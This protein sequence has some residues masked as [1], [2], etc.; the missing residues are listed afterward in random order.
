MPP[1]FQFRG[2]DRRSQNHH[3]KPEFTFRYSRPPTSERPLL[4]SRRETTPDLLVAPEN[5]DDKPALKF[6]PIESLSDSEEADMDVSSDENDDDESRPRKKRALESNKC[7]TPASAPT[8][9]PA[10]KW[11]NPDP[12]T[13]LPPP[14][15]TQS[16]RVDVVKL[17]RKA[18][19][20]ASAQPAKTDAVADNEDFISLGGLVDEEESKYQPPQ[21]APMGPRSQMQGRDSAV[22]SRKRTHDDELK[23]VSKKTG[24]PLNKYYSD[25]SIIDEWRVRP[26]ETGA[27]W[28]NHMTP[29]LHL[30]DLIERLQTAFQSRYYG[31]QLR[32]FGSFASGL[33]LPTADIDLVLLSS[34]FMRHGIK[35]FGERKGQI[36]AFSAFLRNLDIAVPGSIETIAHARVPILKFVDKMTGLRVDLSFDNDSGL[37]ANNTFQQ[38]KSEYPAMPVIVSVIKQFLLLR[39][40]NEVPCGGLGG[41]SITCLVTSLLQHL[42]HGS[43]SQNLGSIL[44]D[45]FEFYGHEFDYETVGIRMEPP[46]YFNKD[47]RLS[48]ED[49]NNA[50]NDVSGGTREIALIFKSFRDA[51]RLLKERMVYTAMAGDQNNSI[52]ESIIAANYDEYTEQRWQLRQ[53][54]QT[55]PRFARYQAPPSPPPPPQSPPPADSAPPPL[56]PNSPPPSQEPKEKMT[57]LQRKQQASRERAARLKRLRPDLPSVPDSITNEQALIIGGYKSQSDMDK[58]LANREKELK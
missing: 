17:I 51:Y 6:A 10:P 11:S 21:D 53:I 22:G 26:S 16:K 57:K 5:G 29:T 24:K 47:A 54:F 7:N 35:T 27:P 36:Y 44:M 41:F 9:P 12:Y 18:R 34:N 40:L 15:E 50:D 4:R 2:N 28:F 31:V 3:P 48:I 46:G 56:P 20:A 55:H 42:P 33:Y 38:W 14:D 52:L 13:V 58:D 30:A 23:G 25:G 8:P 43:M 39:G 45:F 1:P 37:V 19:I 49:P 32:A